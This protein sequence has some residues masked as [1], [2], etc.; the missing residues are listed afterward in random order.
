[1]GGLP[2]S[3]EDLQCAVLPSPRWGSLIQ[4]LISAKEHPKPE[5]KLGACRRDNEPISATFFAKIRNFRPAATLLS[6]G[7]LVRDGKRW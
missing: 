1:V 5:S 7:R 3:F 6:G 2:R 4:T